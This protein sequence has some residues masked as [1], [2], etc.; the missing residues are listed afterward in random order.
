MTK[1]RAQ[2]ARRSKTELLPIPHNLR[3]SWSLQYHLALSTIRAGHGNAFFLGQIARVL[4]ISNFLLG[5]GYEKD[6]LQVLADAQDAIGQIQQAGES[7]GNW[8]TREPALW[9]P[10]AA[11]LVLYD[12]QL[13]RAPTFEVI[14]AMQ[15]QERAAEAADNVRAAELAL[16]LAA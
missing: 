11:L 4:M 14:Q 12:R 9:R 7:T 10:I 13:S 1:K 3:D 5:A 6:S 8:S 15:Q 2:V 16:P